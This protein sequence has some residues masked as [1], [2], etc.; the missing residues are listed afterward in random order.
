V[1]QSPFYSSGKGVWTVLKWKIFS[2][3]KY[4]VDSK[5]NFATNGSVKQANYVQGWCFQFINFSMSQGYRQSGIHILEYQGFRLNQ[6]EAHLAQTKD[7]H[8]LF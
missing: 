8:Q 2:I 1:G 4:H 3:P 5:L 6:P 7:I